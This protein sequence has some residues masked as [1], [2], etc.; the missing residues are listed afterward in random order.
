MSMDKKNLLNMTIGS[1]IVLLLVWALPWRLVDWGSL[2]FEQAATITVTGEA[3]NRV[4]NQRA[5]FFAGVTAINDDKELAVD[6]VNEKI[7]TITQAV[8]DFGIEDEYIQTQSLSVF[9]M[10]EPVEIE[11][12]TRSQ[13]GQWRVNNNIQIILNDIDRASELATLLTRSGATNVHGPNFNVGPDRDA[14]QDLISAAVKDA[15]EKAEKAVESVGKKV[16]KVVSIVEGGA[17]GPPVMMRAEGL[18]GGGTPL[19]P[20]SSEVRQS[21]TVTFELE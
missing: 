11:G 15:R 17:S 2:T 6:E 16:G 14:G 8:K 7:A 20:G 12:R 21:V 3:R 9:Q 5:E 10:E 1:L 19:Q 13:T 4:E 18:G